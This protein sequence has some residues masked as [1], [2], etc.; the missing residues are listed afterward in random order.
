MIARDRLTVG[1]D[2]IN[3]RKRIDD[4]LYNESFR[5]RVVDADRSLQEF[6]AEP[7]RG[8]NGIDAVNVFNGID[9]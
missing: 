5:M 4:F 6:R 2:Q 9:D 3:R 8:V 7:I 1:P